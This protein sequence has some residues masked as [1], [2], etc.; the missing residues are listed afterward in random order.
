MKTKL[1]ILAVA[2][3]TILN[4]QLV[5]VSMTTEML[6]FLKKLITMVVPCGS[7]DTMRNFL[8]PLF[9]LII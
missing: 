6:A 9:I 5:L 7:T 8:E 4:A 3:S 1:T 2:L